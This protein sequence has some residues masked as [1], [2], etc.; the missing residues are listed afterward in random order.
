LDGEVKL[1]ELNYEE[2]DFYR[3]FMIMN[4][5]FIKPKT[6]V[7]NTKKVAV[8]MGGGGRIQSFDTRSSL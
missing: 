3:S 5:I 8:V 2:G 1:I 4:P 6:G 7:P